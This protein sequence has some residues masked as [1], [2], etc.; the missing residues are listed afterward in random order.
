MISLEYTKVNNRVFSILKSEIHAGTII[1]VFPRINNDFSVRIRYDGIAE[2]VTRPRKSSNLFA[3][4]EEVSFFLKKRLYKR[5]ENNKSQ[6]AKLIRTN[7]EIQRQL[8]KLG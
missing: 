8:T 5:I 2:T 4:K 1:M 6:I 7:E 3:S